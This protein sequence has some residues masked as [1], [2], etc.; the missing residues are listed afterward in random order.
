LDRV[1]NDEAFGASVANDDLGFSIGR[2]LNESRT[3]ECF[4][5]RKRLGLIK[6]ERRY[7]PMA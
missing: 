1:E 4:A 3:A 7:P 2:E 5:S 6:S